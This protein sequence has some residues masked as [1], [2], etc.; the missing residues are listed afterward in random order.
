MKKL[1]I[2]SKLQ[3]ALSKAKIVLND[4]APEILV[5]AG[6]GGVVAA[7]IVACKV[8][9]N[10]L[11]DILD[12]KDELVDMIE[13]STYPE[14]SEEE[15]AADIEHSIKKVNRE[16]RW[17]ICKA[18]ALP[19]GMA[20]VGIAAILAGNHLLRKRYV[21]I[22]A[23][24]Q[25]LQTSYDKYRSRIV[26]KYGEAADHYAAYGFEEEEYEDTEVDPETGKEVKVKKTRTVA[27]TD[28]TPHSPYFRYITPS[29]SLYRECHGNPIYMRNQLEIYEN[30]CNNIYDEGGILYFNE[31]MTYIFGKDPEVMSDDGQLVGWYKYDKKNK[32]LT[33]ARAVDFRIGTVCNHNDETDLDE[34]WFYIDPNVP[35][36]VS[37]GH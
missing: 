14:M 34:I 3:P 13:N 9:A 7:G 27:S 2:I 37:L 26:D 17:K 28:A 18:Y 1:A 36:P 12:E 30:V 11:P 32:A 31:V 8:T 25:A 29:D 5:V 15:N 24:M 16:T 19:V 23:G 6:I 33:D 10:K 35:G 21:A 4:K 22:V 20:A